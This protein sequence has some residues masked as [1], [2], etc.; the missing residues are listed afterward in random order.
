MPSPLYKAMDENDSEDR[1]EERQ[2]D[3]DSF[4]DLEIPSDEE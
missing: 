2:G 3:A 1:D 4:D